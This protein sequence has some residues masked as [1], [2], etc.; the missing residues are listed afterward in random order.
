MILRGASPQLVVGPGAPHIDVSR[1]G[2]VQLAADLLCHQFQRRAV[3]QSTAQPCSKAAFSCCWCWASDRR[4]CQSNCD[5]QGSTLRMLDEV[6]WFKWP[7]SG[8]GTGTILRVE[9]KLF[10]ILPR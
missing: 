3:L 9:H 5:V 8:L 4:A 7:A 2:E 6:L 1:P 10:K